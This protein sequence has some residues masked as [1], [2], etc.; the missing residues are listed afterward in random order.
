[1]FAVHSALAERIA[2]MRAAVIS[3]EELT[4]FSDEQRD[5]LTL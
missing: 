3:G 5:D 1:M 2:L 4:I